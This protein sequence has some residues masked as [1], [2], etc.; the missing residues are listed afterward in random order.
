[1]NINKIAIC[2]LFA[3]TTAVLSQVY[4]P[5]PPIPFNIALVSVF[6]SGIILGPKYGV[7]SQ[8]IFLFMGTIGIPV[9]AGFNSGL[10]YILGPTG[11]YIIGYLLTAYL[12]PIISSKLGSGFFKYLFSM[13]VGLIACYLIGT[14]WFMYVTKSPLVNALMLCVLPF[15]ITD[16]LKI[17]ICTILVCKFNLKEKFKL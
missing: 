11:G 10:G 5:V 9:F 7:I 14:A 3:A 8:F 4:V 13:I 16:L 12:T 2:S 6:L 1:M 17:Y 15:I